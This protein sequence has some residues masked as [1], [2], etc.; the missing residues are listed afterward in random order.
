VQAR[1]A[2]PALQFLKDKTLILK[3]G[4]VRVALLHLYHAL[5]VILHVFTAVYLG[6][7]PPCD[8]GPES[9]LVT[10]ADLNRRH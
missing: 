10:D 1:D 2:D 6:E 9:E 3:R 8:S 5:V 7:G 4:V